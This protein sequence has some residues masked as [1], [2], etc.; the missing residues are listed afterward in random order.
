MQ[1]L[2][3]IGFCIGVVAS[4][5]LTAVFLRMGVM[6]DRFPL[7]NERERDISMW[8]P[9]AFTRLSVLGYWPLFI[10]G[11]YMMFQPERLLFIGGITLLFGLV[12]FLFTALVFS[13][14]VYN[15]MRSKN[16]EVGMPAPFAGLVGGPGA[17]SGGLLP[18]LK[19]RTNGK[20]TRAGLS[21]YRK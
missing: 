10:V 20:F 5:M 18:S 15:L 4:L 12:L 16:R 9:V 1:E 7:E 6:I 19:M 17:S 2:L 13:V 11:G 3:I 14:A 8:S 21:A